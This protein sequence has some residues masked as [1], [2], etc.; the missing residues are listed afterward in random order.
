MKR[1]APALILILLTLAVGWPRLQVWA[2]SLSATG[3][4]N[5]TFETADADEGPMVSL[6]LDRYG[7]PHVSYYD[8]VEGDLKYA[9][10]GT[11]GGSPLWWTDT[12]DSEGYVGLHSSIALDPLDGDRPY[13]SYYDLSTGNLEYAWHDNGWQT[14][15]YSAGSTDEG[16]YTSLKVLDG[17][18]YV[19]YYDVT[20]GDLKFFSGGPGLW[21]TFTTV[22]SAG[23]VGQY[24]SLDLTG[25]DQPRISYYD[26][27]RNRLLYAASY[28]GGTT[29]YT[30]TIDCAT[31]GGQGTS[32]VVDPEGYPHV[33]YLAGSRL[34]YATPFLNTMLC[35]EVT[36][37]NAGGEYTSLALD[38]D[39]HAHIAYTGPGG[40]A[41][42]YAE[43]D[44]SDWQ[45][46]TLDASGYLFSSL[47]L[48]GKGNP[49]VA[50][51]NGGDGSSRY[52]YRRER[53]YL[54]LIVRG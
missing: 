1:A 27:T 39:L 15:N 29:W 5:W 6:A 48:D 40:Y 54:P 3:I 51:Y 4:A 46:T 7:A 18:L 2:T 24:S 38:A 47:A 41:V 30:S 8:Q 31:N 25:D 17:R 53:L 11:L 23:D 12:V 35:V 37:A 26:A 14:T 45:V 34:M 49:H 28:D 36:E 16:S 10:R 13:I 52:A 50:Y 44:G 9:R 42:R 20:H 32:L 22:D 33:S 21:P 43:Y 19:S